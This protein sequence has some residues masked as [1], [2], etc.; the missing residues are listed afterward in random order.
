MKRRLILCIWIILLPTIMA[1]SSLTD[2]D[3]TLGGSKNG[4]GHAGITE[5]DSYQG[6]H[7]IGLYVVPEKGKYAR[8]YVNYDHPLP[9]EDL[10]QLSMW[11][12]PNRGSGRLTLDI[13]FDSGSKIS[14]S[15]SWSDNDLGK[16]QEL[17]AFD[18]NFGDRSLRECQKDL[19]GNGIK[20]IWIRLY[21]NGSDEVSAYL[22]YLKIRDQVISFEPLEKE[23]VLD[24]PSSASPGG[25]I[26]Y[27]ITYVGLTQLKLKTINN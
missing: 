18:L 2:V 5:E 12:K 11:L 19:S 16:W 13:Y 3:Y 8:I 7:S 23:N 14:S 10:D 21:N 9:I 22:D 1:G 20:K 15:K 4:K 6:P 27:I 25:K 17:D 26:T 24:A